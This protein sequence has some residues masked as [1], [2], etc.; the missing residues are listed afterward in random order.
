MKKKKGFKIAYVFE[1]VAFA[2]IV[3]SAAIF[4]LMFLT[5]G[6]TMWS[7]MTEAEA[8]ANFEIITGGMLLSFVCLLEEGAWLVLEL[9]KLMKS[10]PCGL[11]PLFSEA[12]C[13]RAERFRHGCSSP[14]RHR[15]RCPLFSFPR[16]RFFFRAFVS[17]KALYFSSENILQRGRVTK[18]I[19]NNLQSLFVYG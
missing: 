15:L 4:A 18:K 6:L 14:V 16:R 17:S 9:T 2:G 19:Y 10:F 7:D 1:F 13:S 12:F 5:Q 8:E 3:F 11:F